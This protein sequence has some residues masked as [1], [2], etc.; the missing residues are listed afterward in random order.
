MN[1]PAEHD[2]VAQYVQVIHDP[3]GNEKD[4]LDA[5]HALG[6]TKAEAAMYAL[7]YALKD[8]SF[9][10]RWAAAEALAE[11]GSAAIAP[12]MHALIAG[13]H[14]FVREGAHHV[15]SRLPGSANH[16]LVKPVLDALE[17]RTPSISVPVAAN[18]VLA[19]LAAA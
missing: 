19:H 16:Q 2:V 3:T 1:P 6:H 11:H 12:I 9:A 10:V 8:N 18:A 5:C 13:D 15:L 14:P 4:R 7:I 17:G